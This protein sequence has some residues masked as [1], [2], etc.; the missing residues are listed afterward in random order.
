MAASRPCLVSFGDHEHS[1]VLAVPQSLGPIAQDD[2]LMSYSFII[3]TMQRTGGTSLTELLMDMSEHR[4]AEPEPFNGKRQFGHISRAWAESRDDAELFKVLGEIFSQRYLIKHCYELHPEF[5]HRLMQAAAKTDYR[6]VHL[7]RRDELSRLISKFVAQS[8]GTWHK[9]YA[10][11]IFAKVL[12]GRRALTPLPVGQIVEHY[13]KCQSIG[14]EI[15]ALMRELGI[16][17]LEIYYEDL[18]KGEREVRVA[19]L[20]K[21]LEFLDFNPSVIE[22]H[23]ARIEEKIFNNGQDTAAVMPSVPNI[24]EVVDA[25]VAAGCPASTEIAMPQADTLPVAAVET[26]RLSAAV[27]D[28][29]SQWAFTSG[30]AQVPKPGRRAVEPAKA[31]KE[32][33]RRAHREFAAGQ[34]RLWDGRLGDRIGELQLEFLKARGLSPADRLIDIGCGALGGGAQLIRYLA[35]GGYYGIDMHIEPIV[36]G[37]AQELGLDLFREK[38]PRFAVSKRFELRKFGEKFTFGIAQSVFTHL[39]AKDIFVCLTRLYRSADQG[40]RFYASFFEAADGTSASDSRK[41]FRHTREELSTL[42]AMIGW[43]TAYI[44]EWGHPRGQRMMEF[45]RT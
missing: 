21:L 45:V 43:R 16:E 26:D 38:K 19:W 2:Q 32:T 24:R 31:R 4:S 13:N 41:I 20:R 27:Q 8:H 9:P 7:M 1:I 11:K 44:G 42:G 39:P 14:G 17:F 34:E 18:Y 40:C 6:H 30:P 10:S 29:R 22:E 28:W 35:P 3:W 15:R 37:V 33:T 36:Y 25:L 12:E 23:R 5:S